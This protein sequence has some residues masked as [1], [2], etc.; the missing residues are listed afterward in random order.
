MIKQTL[1]LLGMGTAVLALSACTLFEKDKKDRPSS[2]L[3]PGSY[4][5]TTSS[6]DAQ[7]TTRTSTDTIDISVDKRGRKKVITKSKKTKDPRGLL[8]K[9]TIEESEHTTEIK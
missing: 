2:L 4:E 7:G 1:S 9:T 8:N 3:S 6:T 5:H